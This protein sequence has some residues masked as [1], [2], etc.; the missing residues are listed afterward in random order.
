VTT[1]QT[2]DGFSL[3]LEG[4]V[5]GPWVGEL[6]RAWQAAQK[7]STNTATTVDLSA[8][9]FADW[10]GRKLLLEMQSQG[11]QLVGGSNFLRSLLDGSARLT[12]QDNNGGTK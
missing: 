1:R 12:S 8:V 3:I 4:R 6:E 2:N 7:S 9:S 11:A 10:R 5:K